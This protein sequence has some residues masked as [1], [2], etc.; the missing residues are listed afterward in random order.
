[1][2]L[3]N[4]IPVIIALVTAFLFPVFFAKRKKQRGKQ[5]REFC[6]HLHGIGIKFV[7][8]DKDSEEVKLAKKLSRGQKPEGIIA[9][10]NKNID[11]IVVT[12]VASQYGVNY[13]IEY[14][15]K[16]TFMV[17]EGSAQRTRMVKKRNSLFEK[18]VT[19]LVW[20][21]DFYLTQKLNMDY[22]LKHR[23]LQADLS[24]FKGDIKILPDEKRGYTR[25]KTNFNL[26]TY[27]IFTA[28]DSIA[29]YVKSG[30]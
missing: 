29:L 26:P 11:F 18:E 14:L 28:I 6:D 13:F 9:L 27:E 2:D 15:I 19:D 12:S 4:I 7:E 20:K 3:K 1:M 24:K 10:E 25:I 5:Y 21:G 16:T 22:E 8:L 17:R 23:L 30:I